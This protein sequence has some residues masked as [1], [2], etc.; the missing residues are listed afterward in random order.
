[1]RFAR[2]TPLLHCPGQGKKEKTKKEKKKDKAA[3]LV[4]IMG[5]KTRRNP[6]HPACENA[7]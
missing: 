1:M 6:L 7:L 5:A 2:V 4:E 3:A